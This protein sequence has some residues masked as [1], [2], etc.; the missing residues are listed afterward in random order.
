MEKWIESTTQFYKI[1]RLTPR[2][3]PWNPTVILFYYPP[4]VREYLAEEKSPKGSNSSIFPC[5]NSMIF[6]QAKE[7]TPE[8]EWRQ[9]VHVVLYIDHAHTNGT[10]ADYSVHRVRTIWDKT[11]NDTDDHEKDRLDKSQSDGESRVQCARLF[12]FRA[13]STVVENLIWLVRRNVS[14]IRRPP[15]SNSESGI[16]RKS[17]LKPTSLRRLFRPPMCERQDDSSVSPEIL[18]V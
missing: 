5:S 14:E 2:R 16:R 9:N 15:F 8:E 11:K 10:V 1:Q 7:S 6:N 17:V 18:E 3:S 12:V 13:P 4:P